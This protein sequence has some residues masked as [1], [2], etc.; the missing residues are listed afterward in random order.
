MVRNVFL[1]AGF[2]AFFAI[3]VPVYRRHAK[4][5]ALAM[6]DEDGLFKSLI[7][8]RF[9]VVTLVN[10]GNKTA[11]DSDEAREAMSRLR[12]G[13]SQSGGKAVYS[14][15][16]AA[17]VLPSAQLSDRWHGVLLASWASREA[18][19]EMLSDPAS[20]YVKALQ[21]YSR[22]FQQ[23]MARSH[24]TSFFLPLLTWILKAKDTLLMR[25]SPL[26]FTKS[27]AIGPEAAAVRDRVKQGLIG[28]RANTK[29]QTALV[30][31]NFLRTHPDAEK[32]ALNTQY[33]MDMLSLFGHAGIAGPIS[34]GSSV[35]LPES[36]K[37]LGANAGGSKAVTH[38]WDE[39]AIVFYPGSPFFLDMVSSDF[40]QKVGKHKQL[41]DTLACL[42]VPDGAGQ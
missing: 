31:L 20:P 9:H 10:L 28:F 38:G 30:M 13:V 35:A 15:A 5:R 32:A 6:D 26:P 39:V 7:S 4:M 21:R 17:I 36:R 3:A 22:I 27:S 1:T 29:H 37:I 11:P 24:L 42:T 33:S 16:V 12:D 19:K 8:Q 41:G 23:G 25:P 2:V 18:H 34:L 14:G 40:M